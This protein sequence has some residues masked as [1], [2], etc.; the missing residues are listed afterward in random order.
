MEHGNANT[1]KN[2]C[3]CA[4]CKA[5]NSL[6]NQERRKKQ[7]R[8]PVEP[9]LAHLPVD[10]EASHKKAIAAWAQKGLSI[11]EVDR[12]CTRHGLHPYIVY[13]TYWYSDMWS[14]EVA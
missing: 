6:R 2:G 5:S 11:F 14:E 4:E 10:F 1:Y 8:F 9:L 7:L 12:I 3:R 13:G